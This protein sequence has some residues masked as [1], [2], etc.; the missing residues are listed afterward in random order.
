MEETQ[1]ALD[2][3][4]RKV[5]DDELSGAGFLSEGDNEAHITTSINLGTGLLDAKVKILAQ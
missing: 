3:L 5:S 4:F 2:R 1:Q